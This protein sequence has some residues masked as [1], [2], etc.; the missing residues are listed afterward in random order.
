M[1]FLLI[2]FFLRNHRKTINR[3]FP[4]APKLKTPSSKKHENPPNQNAFFQGTPSFSL[5]LF[6]KICYFSQPGASFKKR[7]QKPLAV[8][9]KTSL[10]KN[11]WVF[12]FWTH[13][14]HLGTISVRVF[15]DPKAKA[16]CWGTKP[17]KTIFLRVFFFFQS[18][19]SHFPQ[20][21]LLTQKPF[22]SVFFSLL[23][24]KQN[25]LGGVFF[26]QKPFSCWGTP[27]S[28]SLWWWSSSWA[29]PRSCPTPSAPRWASPWGWQ[30][31]WGDSSF[32]SAGGGGGGGGGG[33]WTFFFFKAK[34]VF[35]LMFFVSCVAFGSKPEGF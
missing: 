4:K 20:G 2:D 32:R 18:H 8:K 22:P 30:P 14:E 33:V 23:D 24:P 1:C 16:S 21:F 3:C 19:Q 11:L 28:A 6:S 15:F 29:S 13:L 12:C 7:Q 26:N 31:S 34:N 27:S 5:F 17:T 10:P 9:E 35:F 25:H